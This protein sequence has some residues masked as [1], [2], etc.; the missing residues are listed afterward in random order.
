MERKKEIELRVLL[1]DDDEDEYILL[2]DL[3]DKLSLKPGQCKIE[4]DWV[5]NFETA[6][7]ALA[8]NHYDA[9]LVDYN[10]GEHSGLDVLREINTQGYNTTVILLTGQG[11]YEIDLAAMQEGA[12]DYLLKD[13]LDAPLLERTIR[14]AIEH[15]KTQEELEVR[16]RERTAALEQA[17][18][19]LKAEIELRTEVERELRAIKAEL[20]DRVKE[21]T[22]ELQQAN[23]SLDAIFNHIAE[24][25]TVYDEKG[26]LLKA[27]Q[28]AI[29]NLGLDPRSL[30]RED[31]QETF[32]L[33]LPDGS[34]VSEEQF[35]IQ[36]A[37]R[38]ETVRQ[39]PYLYRGLFGQDF[40]I[41][42]SATP[43][44]SEGELTGVVAI[45]HDVTEREQLVAQLAVEQNRLQ[46]IIQNAASGIV[47]AD[48]TGSII[49]TNPIAE[50]I[51]GRALPKDTNLADQEELELC[52]PDGT[53]YAA[54]D[55]I[56]TRAAKEGKAFT[57]VEMLVKSSGQDARYILANA[58]PIYDTRGRRNGAVGVFQDITT[59]KQLEENLHRRASRAQLLA[60]LSKAF[61][62]AGLDDRTV[63]DTI[64]EKIAEHVGDAC[65][66]RLIS[67]DGEWLEPVSF[68]V[69]LPEAYERMKQI[70]A[71]FRQHVSEGPSGIVL[72]TGKPLLIPNV[73]AELTRH[74]EPRS[75]WDWLD[76]Y[77]VYSLLV[78]PLY[79]KER[80]LGSLLLLR[81][82][83]QDTNQPTEPYTLE[84]LQ[85]F[86]DLSGRAALAI[87][88]ARLYE[89]VQR[90]SV[91][92]PLTGL[93]NRRGLLTMGENELRR[94]HR[95]RHPTAMIMVDIDHFK[96]VN[97]TYGHAVGDDVLRV[98]AE[99]LRHSL[100]TQ[101]ILARY[102]GE[103]FAILVPEC[104][105]QMAEHVAERLRLL[106]DSHPVDTPSGEV[107]IT[108]SLGA[109]VNRMMQEDLLVLLDRAD[110]A[111]YAAKQAGRNCVIVAE[112]K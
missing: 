98:V 51:L 25:V 7:E 45:A 105:S 90:L 109:A 93:F 32:P 73:Q 67:E 29:Q 52:Y 106:F 92:D 112:E 40:Y 27:N 64:T 107:A 86:E 102:G 103:E 70:F 17:N 68:S 54:E 76:R 30:S 5:Y 8:R 97:D 11:N 61:V 18:Q 56:L 81:L 60:V 58:T 66:L 55:M 2:Q 36:R 28:V 89:E 35:P 10:L 24:A 95:F 104:N 9:C 71:T 41:L 26:K 108:V 101:D 14:Y 53:P 77:S 23:L 39:E 3:V 65:V 15:K 80:P 19:E 79:V 13:Q 21:R 37:M 111:L 20:E 16:V 38:G 31:S 12:A 78:V 110:S 49:L 6:I 87:E 72:R 82:K 63:L 59:R 88:N 75:Y 46:A 57:N 22:E 83:S 69:N 1:V 47:V 94:A 96:K 74:H 42:L 85:F 34:P 99:R 62:E 100:R 48:N 84:D 50:L 91:T 4:L 43:M 33:L 44:Y